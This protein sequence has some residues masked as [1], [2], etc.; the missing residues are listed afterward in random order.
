MKRY[1]IT[2]LGLALLPSLFAAQ[3]PN[4]VFV[5]TDDHAAH[6][7]SAYGS[8]INTTPNMDRLATEGMLFEKCYVSNAICGPSR[9]VILTGKYS[10]LNGFLKN[11]RQ[12]F[13]GSQ[14]TFPKLLRKVG[15]TT[16][17][18]GKWHLMP[19]GTPEMNDY[20]PQRHGFDVNIGGNQ[21]GAPGSYF[22]PY[23]SRRRKIG[24]LPPGGKKGDYL[25]DRLTDEALKQLEANQENP[26]LLYFP[27][28]NVHTPLQGKPELVAKYQAR[29][30][31]TMKHQH[32]VYAS[33][34]QSVDECVG[35]V[36][37]ELD[38]LGLTEETLILF[39]SDNGGAGGLSSAPLRGGKGSAWEGGVREP[40]IAWW[41]GKVPAGSV[42]K[43]IAST[44]DLL[45]T[46]A[47][48]AGGKVPDDRVIDGKDVGDLFL[49][50]PGA[51]T[52]HDRFFYH[53]ADNLRAVRSGPWKLFRNGPLYNLENDLGEKKNVAA[54]HPNVVKRLTAYMNRFEQDIKKNSRPIGKAKNP[55]TLVP[56]PGA[57]GEDAYTPTLLIGKTK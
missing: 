55:R 45:P 1:I 18:I 53:Q 39:T 19:R 37:D 21:W 54:K 5:F 52:P 43:E 30:R 40:T 44:M 9:A 26:F 2:L 8:K 57:E 20:L 32:A 15:Y 11:Q 23:A 7:I 13:D 41:P 50:K 29:V 51:K 56:R 10:H 17:V 31:P 6:A 27:Y 3:R 25:T 22:F 49:G 46:F 12:P 36:L 34:V 38:A 16:A 48:W 35:R 24:V 33:M 47:K 14:Q 42:C 28:Y 4:I